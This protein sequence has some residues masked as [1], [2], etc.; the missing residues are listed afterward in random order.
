[1]AR[2]RS[3]CGFRLGTRAE[4]A[5]EAHQFAVFKE[6]ANAFLEALAVALLDAVDVVQRFSLKL[7]LISGVPRT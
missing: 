3:G 7:S 6:Q 4:V 5:A 2:R 1:M